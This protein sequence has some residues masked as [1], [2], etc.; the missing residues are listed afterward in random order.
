[1]HKDKTYN[2]EINLAKV[3]QTIWKGKIKLL[4]ILTIS[5]FCAISINKNQPDQVIEA[6]TPIIKI[7]EDQLSIFELHNS[8]DI[9]LVDSSMLYNKFINILERRKVIKDSIRKFKI[10]SKKK[11]EN[12]KKYEEAVSIASFRVLKKSISTESISTESISN[13]IILRGTDRD[14]LIEIIGYIKAEN[15]KLV[16]QDI[17]E[18]FKNKIKLLKEVDDIEKNNIKIKIQHSKD[19]YDT[20]I[21]KKKQSLE[22]QIEDINLAIKNSFTDYQ[23]KIS[24][25]I[26]YLK[27]Q[28]EIARKLDIAKPSMNFKTFN[29]SITILGLNKSAANSNAKSM[30]DVSNDVPF[31]LIG[32][33]AIEK[34][35]DIIKNRKNTKD[36]L[37][38]EELLKTKRILSQDKSEIRKELNKMYLNEIISYN[39][40]LRDI[41]LKELFYKRAEILFNGN[42]NEFI[43]K[44]GSVIFDPYSTV[45]KSEP[46]TSFFRI[47]V[48]TIFLGSLIG[49]FYVI[50]EEKIKKAY[51]INR[52]D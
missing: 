40:E 16:I 42:L 52:N 32:Y 37:S 30:L 21:K 29:P 11:Y 6:L 35:I 23:N 48:L 34:E 20:K 1:M 41:D 4:I 46:K 25:R 44:S 9:Y 43:K 47:L 14:K 19:D 8:N 13:K 26:Q 36:Y 49:L 22:F 7:S 24:K 38:N 10:V 2:D 12:N 27:E 5:I 50:I 28:A 17:R 33:E 31:Y 18:E 39:K 3:F 45:F 15:E 51:S